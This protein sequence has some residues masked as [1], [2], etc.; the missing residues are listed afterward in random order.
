MV[1][2]AGNLVEIK[3]DVL[4]DFDAEVL[5][6]HL[7]Q[8][9]R[10]VILG[11]VV[12]PA[13]LPVGA[14]H[15]RVADEGGQHHPMGAGVKGHQH[16]AVGIA[17]VVY[18]GVPLVDAEHQVMVLPVEILRQLFIGDNLDGLRL[19]GQGRHG[20]QQQRHGK[21]QGKDAFHLQDSLRQNHA[22]SDNHND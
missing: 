1:D 10:A 9:L 2:D 16:N 4:L 11:D 14:L 17:Q 13:D 21:D 20:A 18:L 7:A 22:F 12:H 8:L 5:A 19:V 15:Q 6:E 3:E